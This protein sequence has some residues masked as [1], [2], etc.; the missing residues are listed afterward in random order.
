M[1]INFFLTAFIATFMS[2]MVLNPL[3]FKAGLMDHPG[4]R[5][6][7]Q[8]STP[9]T[10]GLAV[11]VAILITLFIHD[12]SLPNKAAY[13]FAATIL[14]CIGLVDDF[15]PLSFK[16]R[17]LAQI[18]VGLLMTQIADIKIIDLG[19]LWHFGNFELGV[20]ASAFTIFALAGGI[21][22]FNMAD[23]IDGL[24][25]GLTLIAIS[26]VAVLAWAYDEIELLNYCVIFIAAIIVFLL[27]NLRVFGQAST[28]IFLGDTG[29]TLFGF[30]VSLLLIYISQGE[31]RLITP[32][33]VLW[34]LAIPLIDSVSTMMRRMANG[35]SPFFPDREHF[36]HILPLTGLNNHQT[37]LVIL[38]SSLALSIIGIT[39]SQV[40]HVPDGILLFLFMLLFAGHYV[41]MGK[42]NERAKKERRKPSLSS[43][44]VMTDRRHADRRN[45]DLADNTVVIINRRNTDRRVCNMP[46][47]FADKRRTERRVSTKLELLHNRTR[48]EKEE[49][50]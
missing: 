47:I 35:R 44:T 5:K 9:L 50:S 10:G 28:K 31:H 34:I 24:V 46:I 15:K 45:A 14:V 49:H 30:I 6:H 19:D 29:S 18:A 23:G 48:F 43:S 2:I 21:N 32:V 33:T 37:L 7:H 1:H 38:A 26:S 39:A 17:M 40:L 41:A 27:F 12:I 3:A 11:Y 13:I 4:H 8:D 20:F 36:H 22:A 42:I 16:V 25:G